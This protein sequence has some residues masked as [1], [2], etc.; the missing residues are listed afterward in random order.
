MIQRD[1]NCTSK[2]TEKSH[3]ATCRSRKRRA[4]D[5]IKYQWQNLKDRAKQRP[6]EFKITLEYFR[7]WCKDVNFVIGEDSVDRKD[8]NIGYIE[9]NLNKI[10]LLDNIRKYWDYDRK[11]K[12]MAPMTDKEVETKTELLTGEGWKPIEQ[13][14]TF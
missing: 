10:P 11:R 7:M 5:Q 13:D 12:G 1:N 3:S 4:A 6:K 14:I 8:N 9:G 2:C